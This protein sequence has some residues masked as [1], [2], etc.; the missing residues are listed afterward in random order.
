MPI[1]QLSE[2]DL[3]YADDGQGPAIVWLQGLGA[4]HAA[5]SAQVF[6][7]QAGFR[8]VRPD[9]RGVGQTRD[10]GGD[11]TIGELARDVVGLL[12]HLSIEA[13]HVVGLSFGGAIAQ[14]LA[15]DY[16]ERVRALVLVATFARRDPWGDFLLRAWI[17]L[18]RLVGPGEFFRQALPWLVTEA[19]LANERRVR[20]LLDYATRHAQTSEDFARQARASLDHNRL[21][22]LP[23]IGA[24]TLV[25]RG[26][27]DLLSPE[28]RSQ[29][30]ATAIPGAEL[31]TIP[32]A[33]HSV[34]LEQQH[35]F[36]RAVRE[37]LSR[38]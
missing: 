22:D 19:T 34:N 15:I 37:F 6:I 21:T 13:A 9:N 36:N 30:I 7:F 4:D 11:F 23:R 1:V 10:R 35:L 5:W 25:I 38:W 32:D 18:H 29:E 24:P 16:P 26:A 27:R 12:D 3:F 2:V 20:N 31:L 8:C 14:A 33:G 17:D 28:G